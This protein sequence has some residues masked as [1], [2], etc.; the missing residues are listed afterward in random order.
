MVV[1][2]VVV[3]VVVRALGGGSLSW[4]SRN[5]KADEDWLGVEDS[6]REKTRFHWVKAWR[7]WL[8][9]ADVV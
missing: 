1:V 5:E 8:A 4:P 3:V 6:W 2:V 9:A 7:R